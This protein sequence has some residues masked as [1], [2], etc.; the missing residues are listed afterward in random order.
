MNRDEF[1]TI[2]SAKLYNASIQRERAAAGGSTKVML[3]AGRNTPD[4]PITGAIELKAA[5]RVITDE[6]D[7]SKY[8]MTD[9][10]T[11]VNGKCTQVKLGLVGLHIIHKTESQPQWI[12]ATFEHVDNAPDKEQAKDPSHPFTFFNPKCEPKAISDSCLIKPPAETSCS[13]TPVT[14]PAYSLSRYFTDG[15]C[16]PYP[17]QVVRKRA[18]ASSTADPVTSINAAA[19]KLIASKN[20]DSV[21]QHYELVDVLWSQSPDNPYGGEESPV[22]PLSQ[23]GMTPRSSAFPVANTAMET[24]VQGKTCTV[25]HV[26]AHI[27]G[28]KTEDRKYA[29]DFS[30]LLG[31]AT[32]SDSE[33][34]EPRDLGRLL[35]LTTQ[36]PKR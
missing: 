23:S 1:D 22:V 28:L 25:C 17:I 33:T 2:V 34:P 21:F 16:P 32:T 26:L 8:K 7:Y 3:P 27:A 9:A 35:L 18:I 5:W 4:P 24:Y 13:T 20:K 6:S 36:R 12:W 29:S 11:V 30:F 15:Q 14:P 31:M 10:V 19:Q